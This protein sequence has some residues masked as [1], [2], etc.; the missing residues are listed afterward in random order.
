MPSDTR[1]KEGR[2]LRTRRSRY[3]RL[4][5]SL[6]SSHRT[7][8]SPPS[9]EVAVTNAEVSRGPA[10]EWHILLDLPSKHIS[11]VAND[12]K[13]FEQWIYALRRASLFSSRV[14]DY[15]RIRHIVGEG[16]NGKVRLGNDIITDETVAIKTVPRLGRTNEDHFLAREV[17]IMLQV[18]HPNIVKT[19]DIFV[20]RKRIHFVMEYVSG[21]ELFDLVA[22]NTIFTENR[23]ASVMVDLLNAISY[24]HKQNIAHRDVKLEN[25]LCVRSTWPLQVKLADFGFANHIK[26]EADKMLSSFVGTPYYIA[27]EMLLSKGHGRPVDIWACGVVLYILLSGKFPFGGETEKEYYARVLQR[28]V[29]F[30]SAEWKGVSPEAKN[31]VSGMLTKDPSRRLDAEECLRHPWLKNVKKQSPATVVPSKSEPKSMSPLSSLDSTPDSQRSVRS[32]MFLRNRSRIRSRQ[33]NNSQNQQPRSAGNLRRKKKEGSKRDLTPKST[34]RRDTETQKREFGG[35]ASMN[36]P[37]RIEASTSHPDI[38]AGTSSGS[39]LLRGNRLPARAGDPLVSQNSRSRP[40][41]GA[42]LRAS[43]PLGSGQR[44]QSLIRRLLSTRNSMDENRY[45]SFHAQEADEADEAS[46]VPR[47]TIS[48]FGKL[49]PIR[50]SFHRGGRGGGEEGVGINFVNSQTGPGS[51]R[52]PPKVAR[53]QMRAQAEREQK[54]S[55]RG[56]FRFR[57]GTSHNGSS[58]SLSGSDVHAASRSESGG[59]AGEGAIEGMLAG[60]STTPV[61]GDAA[62]AALELSRQKQ[63]RGSLNNRH[64]SDSSS[65]AIGDRVGSELGPMSVQWGLSRKIGQRLDNPRM[66][67]NTSDSGVNSGRGGNFVADTNNTPLSQQQ[68]AAVLGLDDVDSNCSLAPSSASSLGYNW[69]TQCSTPKSKKKKKNLSSGKRVPVPVLVSNGTSA[70]TMSGS[71]TNSNNSKRKM[72]AGMTVK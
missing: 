67:S 18:D 20:R 26:T 60:G 66:Q 2:N 1:R 51:S 45:P 9:W 65:R 33:M 39:N 16:M 56:F 5:G 40:R 6:L 50:R 41:P 10:H 29:Y 36:G 37:M 70:A 21:G 61:L 55:R 68:M 57:F 63:Q 27:P 52:L 3:V 53:E 15:Y 17:Q 62:T 31:L 42:P 49:A 13:Q 19:F 12:K 8:N 64:T 38:G 23:A 30:P 46:A 43:G 71:S 47:K 7:K 22:A 58:P 11:F 28:E 14:E 25:L 59:G 72:S 24:L 69:G 35:A 34:G 48:L 32:P 44:R 54:A 4:R